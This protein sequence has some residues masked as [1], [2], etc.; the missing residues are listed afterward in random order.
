MTVVRRA[1]EKSPSFAVDSFRDLLDDH[2]H[3]LLVT[4]IFMRLERAS[5]LPEIIPGGNMRERIRTIGL[6]GAMALTF[7]LVASGAAFAHS[8]S[9]T[10]EANCDAGTPTIS[11]TVT[12][13]SPIFDGTNPQVVVA[14]N[15]VT[16]FTGAFVEATGNMFSGSAPAPAGASVVVS[17]TAVAAWGDGSGGGESASVT[18]TVPS[19]CVVGGDGRFTGGGNTVELAGYKITKGLTI[20]CDLL[21]SN[22]LE[23]NW[24]GGNNFHMAEH[25]ETIACFDSPSIDQKPPAAPLD[26]LIGRGTGSFNNVPGYTIVF[27]LV[28]AGE[29]GKNDQM[30]F[31]ITAPGG[32][33]V[34]SVPLQNLTGGNLQAHY[35][36]PH[37]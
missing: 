34:L 21:L 36:Q 7:Q 10:A 28:D 19:D 3:T 13:F 25:V 18:V 32:G 1:I 23:I 12:S 30:A 31:T 20:H 9:I 27:T 17:A 8:L 2:K 33:T 24:D 4:E 35:D 11:F 14:F 15:N 29:P 16:V 26:T 6:I 5:R 37:K 22:N